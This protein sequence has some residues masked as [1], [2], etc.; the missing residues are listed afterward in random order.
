M[1][2]A[3]II[4]GLLGVTIWPVVMIAGVM[5]MDQPNVPLRTEILRQIAAYTVLLPPVVW[6]AA[7]VLAIIETKRKKREGRLRAYAAAPYAA[8]GVHGLALVVLFT[9]AK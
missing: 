3:F 1:K 4:S 8:A 6:I 5:L 7:L 9:L 2:R